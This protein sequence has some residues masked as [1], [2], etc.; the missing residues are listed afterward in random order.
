[1]AVVHFVRKVPAADGVLVPA[2]GGLRFTPTARRVIVGAPDVVVLP[3]SFSVQLVNGAADVTLEPTTGAWVWRVDEYCTGTPARTTHVAVP[4][5]AELDD[6]DLVIVD[7]ATL[8]P[9]AVPEPAW[10][11]MA[12]STVT[13][14]TVTGDDLI[15]TRTDGTT[16][17]AGNVRGPQGIQGVQGQQG[18]Q[19]VQGIQGIKGDIGPSGA[20]D[21]IAA[22]RPREWVKVYRV[23]PAGGTGVYTTINAAVSAA[24]TDNDATHGTNTGVSD[25]ATRRL[26]LIDPGTYNESIGQGAPGTP[27][28][29]QFLDFM[30]SS[31]NADDVM[32]W[33][34]GDYSPFNVSGTHYIA[35]IT[36]DLR[37]Y[38][39]ATGRHAL[40]GVAMP[41]PFTVLAENCKFYSSNTATNGPNPVNVLCSD[42]SLYL[43][44]KCHFESTSDLAAQ[45]FQGG[46]GT[47]NRKRPGAIVFLDC[48]A[49]ANS[50]IIS[51]VNFLDAG[52]GQPDMHVWIGGS[53]TK[54]AGGSY[55]IH[56]LN[57]TGKTTGQFVI[58]PAIPDVM[59][60][61]DMFDGTKQVRGKI[62]PAM[63]TGGISEAV[64]HYYAP[65]TRVGFPHQIGT[66][67]ADAVAST[68]TANRIYYVPIQVRD[69][70]KV[71]QVWQGVTTAAGNTAVALYK[72]DGTGKPGTYL[73]RSGYAATTAGIFKG[74]LVAKHTLWPGYG[75]VWAAVVCDSATAQLV[76]SN[77][78]STMRNV[79]YQ[80]VTAGTMPPTTTPTVTLL[81]PG[82]PCPTPSLYAA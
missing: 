81:P 9:A 36:F 48:T 53:I 12:Q 68:V 52:G 78:L 82:S 77:L 31:G 61:A 2:K 28:L 25:Y 34:S 45:A 62:L 41:Y 57:S 67:Q 38:A 79:Y 13:S 35:H 8:E 14:G 75:Q 19:G 30:G 58:D 29:L 27:T 63:P 74:T 59:P 42:D 80:D 54:K 37:G 23:N 56:C 50:G 3:A 44:Y 33:Y 15:L 43:F 5:V 6:T 10:V 65:E 49:V 20:S 70:V 26:I 72:D 76:C 4:D 18:I 17:N 1:M 7:P 51:V 32:V 22:A 60:P 64:R 66:Q 73:S 16:T 21:L 40:N 69:T 46:S 24:K 47:S 55:T 71:Q 39:V 11:A